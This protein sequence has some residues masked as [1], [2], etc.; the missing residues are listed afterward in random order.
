MH[1]V[2]PPPKFA[3]YTHP[4]PP[5]FPEYQCLRP[6]FTLST[7]PFFTPNNGIKIWAKQRNIF[8]PF[9]LSLLPSLTPPHHTTPHKGNILCKKP[10]LGINHNNTTPHPPSGAYW[11]PP[12][13]TPPSPSPPPHPHANSMI[14]RHLAS[15][16]GLFLVVLL[17]GFFCECRVL[18]EHDTF[19]SSQ[20]KEYR[21]VAVLEIADD[22]ASAVYAV[23]C[24]E[25]GVLL[26]NFSFGASQGLRNG[27]LTISQADTVSTLH[28]GD[29]GILHASAGVVQTVTSFKVEKNA[30]NLPSGITPEARV[31]FSS[32]PYSK[33]FNF[34]AKGD[35]MLLQCETTL[36]R[37]TLSSGSIA[38]F[39]NGVF[40]CVDESRGLMFISKGTSLETH[41]T[42]DVLSGA[43]SP[44]S[45]VTLDA[46]ALV[47]TVSGEV[48]YVGGEGF[49]GVYKIGLPSTPL[50]KVAV[51]YTGCCGGLN[52]MAMGVV[53]EALVVSTYQKL[54]LLDV[55]Q[56]QAGVSLGIAYCEDAKSGQGFWQ[57]LALGSLL[58]TADGNRVTQWEIQGGHLKTLAP[59]TLV[60]TGMPTAE[61]AAKPTAEPTAEATT[62]SPPTP[63][64]PTPSPPV[65]VPV[66]V[67]ANVIWCETDA[68]CQM[69][70]ESAHCNSHICDCSSEYVRVEQTGLC[71]VEPNASLSASVLVQVMW[72][73]PC[74]EYEAVFAENIKSSLNEVLVSKDSATRFSCNSLFM[75]IDV[76]FTGVDPTLST[77]KVD[78]QIT[79]H[80][81]AETSGGDSWGRM[82]QTLGNP[83]AFNVR[84]I[85]V[86]RNASVSLG[87]YELEGSQNVPVCTPFVCDVSSGYTL[88]NGICEAG[89]EMIPGEDG[90]VSVVAISLVVVGS[91][92]VLMMVVVVYKLLH[93]G[94]P[95][96]A[97]EASQF[98]EVPLIERPA[99]CAEASELSVNG[100]STPRPQDLAFTSPQQFSL[101]PIMQPSIA[102]PNQYSAPV[103]SNAGS[104]PLVLSPDSK[105][106][107]LDQAPAPA[108]AEPGPWEYDQ[109]LDALC[110]E[111][112]DEIGFDTVA[113]LRG[114]MEGNRS[115][116]IG[117]LHEPA[118]KRWCTTK[119]LGR[120]SY[121]VVYLGELQGLGRRLAMKLCK[122]K[123]EEEAQETAAQVEIFRKVGVHRNVVSLLDV[124]YVCD[125]HSLC[126]FME[127]VDGP[128]LS[129]LALA[130][131]D[132]VEVARI[133]RQVVC[134][135][136]HLHSNSLVHRDIKG[137]NVLLSADRSVA[138]LC[139]FGCLKQINATNATIMQTQ[140]NTLAGSPGWMAP[141]VLDNGPEFVKSGKPADIYSLGCT[142][143]EA[144]N[145]GV[146]PGTEVTN[147]WAWV[148]A[149]KE[150]PHKL[151]ENIATNV[152]DEAKSLML[153]CLQPDPDMRPT[154]DELC[155]H[156]FL[157]EGSFDEG[158]SGRMGGSVMSTS[159]FDSRRQLM[160]QGWLTAEEMSEWV[161]TDTLGKG[162]FGTV[163]L[164]QLANARQVAVKV[165]T[166]SRSGIESVRQQAE[167][168]F[169]LL[170]TL[171][172]PNIVQ[173]LGH[174]WV[175][176]KHLEIFLEL[177][178]SGT[179]RGLVKR[180]PSGRLMESVVRVYTLQVLDAL[181]Y[182]HAGGGGRPPIAHR[183]IKGENLLIDKEGII[184][185]ADFGCSKLF[186]GAEAAGT[187]VGTPNW[188]APEVLS[189]RGATAAK[190]AAKLSYGTKCDIWSLGCTIIEMMGR[191]PWRERS[192]ETSYDIMHRI[193]SSE[194]GP[195]L[196]PDV[197]MQLAAFL[198]KC[199]ERDPAS[200]PSAKELM[201]NKY[202]TKE[203]GSL[204]GHGSAP[205]L[206]TGPLSLLH[207]TSADNLHR[208]SH[209]TNIG[210]QKIDSSIQLVS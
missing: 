102:T 106:P 171:H 139:D 28:L 209:S 51:E 128:T 70:D 20:C 22:A 77:L 163:Y 200:R 67:P 57:V 176:E 199:F 89:K 168:E 154:I 204:M 52:V 104:P 207:S 29:A 10:S 66:P 181:D 91:V 173:C 206:R 189:T 87:V 6:A 61:P 17:C 134:G 150:A 65:P 140:G 8:P 144:L 165:V 103:V 121:G 101:S 47:C 16:P 122:R 187:F 146:P 53:G 43:S 196:P 81:P 195:P 30:N 90:G 118:L 99:S 210:S 39:S 73:V 208:F 42:A 56:G 151:P 148:S 162:S 127:Y 194:G 63:A 131:L 180:I 152:S 55:G 166:V 155:K 4:P 5:L 72:S 178:S 23:G 14:L 179:V 2:F 177:V 120:G 113:T 79:E 38:V 36:L 85:E 119:L 35:T 45:S 75:Q 13:P 59:P 48:L 44:Q 98:V 137:E 58:L 11:G 153:A 27:L 26:V 142:V 71:G 40:N 84:L 186:R 114:P 24:V 124:V 78:Q 145:N 9:P 32:L 198:A 202:L 15:P 161:Q 62:V 135:L 172:H 3:L 167:A 105:V 130:G 21:S 83:A 156:P 129:T 93:R 109:A 94:K 169:R 159:F 175:E 115:R 185:L 107:S 82:K 25:A 191:T 34:Y 197:P 33:C 136:H 60:P 182:L 50:E 157:V 31:D 193:A 41:K 74:D 12:H 117:P 88:N 138:K 133:I 19:S 188:M 49:I 69:Y 125:T 183:D 126:I 149:K 92:L 147:L 46:S 76:V 111:D 174:R 96:Q 201:N 68:L 95:S 203:Y 141:E 123:S 158:R 7:P 143:S 64:P 116:R 54:C 37:V 108:P 18:V 160:A 184:K 192:G 110:F 132:E 97:K 80:Y 100:G 170:E 205:N 190:T 164:G 112:M 1:R 86:C